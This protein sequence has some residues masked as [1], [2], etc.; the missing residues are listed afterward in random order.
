MSRFAQ[1]HLREAKTRLHRLYG[2]GLKEIYDPVTQRYDHKKLLATPYLEKQ[3]RL[4]QIT[5]PGSDTVGGII[6]LGGV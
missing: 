5:L 6:S 4:G 3:R 1:K 2:V